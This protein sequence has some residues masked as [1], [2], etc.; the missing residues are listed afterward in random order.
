MVYF[1]FFYH[2]RIS[3]AKSQPLS[4]NGLPVLCWN[5]AYYLTC[6]PYTINIIL[7]KKPNVQRLGNC[8]C[9][10]AAESARTRTNIQSAVNLTFQ[11]YI[12]VV[13]K[14]GTGY[15]LQ[16]WN[17][18]LKWNQCHLNVVNCLLLTALLH[19]TWDVLLLSLAILSRECWTAKLPVHYLLVGSGRRR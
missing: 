18:V 5:V 2:R 15:P 19:A 11:L 1:D 12:N 3:T 6:K 16:V 14:R 10:A 9:L 7:K 8:H 17:E 4:L 13:S